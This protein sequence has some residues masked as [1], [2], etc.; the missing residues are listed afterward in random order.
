[1][2]LTEIDASCEDATAYFL[3]FDKN[4][5]DKSILKTSFRI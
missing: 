2:Y 4:D 1:M 5:W 3:E